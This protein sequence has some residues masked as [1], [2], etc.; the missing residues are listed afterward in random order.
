MQTD[1]SS[2]PHAADP[3]RAGLDRIRRIAGAVL[4]VMGVLFVLA[5]A[6][7]RA[8]PPGAELLGWVQA[9]A[10]A[11]LAGGLADWFAVTALFRRPLGLPIPHTAIIPQNRDRIGR[12][13]GDFIAG[14]LVTPAL[15]DRALDRFD[16]AALIPEL[17]ARTPRPELEAMLG[18]AVRAALETAPLAPAAGAALAGFWTPERSGVLIRRAVRLLARTLDSRHDALRDTLVSYGTGWTPKFVD[19]MLAD[20]VL[21]ALAGVLTDLEAADHPWRE[22]LDRTVTR[23]IG[24]LSSDPQMAVEAETWKTALLE[25]ESVAAMARGLADRLAALNLAPDSAAALNQAVRTGLRERILAERPAL[26]RLVSDRMN[27]WDEA[28]LVAELELQ[29][30]RDLQY[31]RING[32]LVGGLV[33]LVI[34]AVAGAFGWR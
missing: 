11:G 5:A 13:L 22:A 16:A 29:A 25:D 21:G 28:A 18:R 27:D 10:E 4:A 32:A 31:I 17:I 24:R 15:V 33:G 26:A 2:P 30:G 19:R 8:W 20:R 34:H 14:Q 23:V 3:R 7:R 9:F 6:G 1:P 12:A